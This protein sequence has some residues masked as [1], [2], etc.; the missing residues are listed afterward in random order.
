MTQSLFEK[1]VSSM[2]RQVGK[3]SGK[4]ISN[5]VYKDA[6]ATP[7]RHVSSKKEPASQSNK[8][9]PVPQK[10]NRNPTTQELTRQILGNLYKEK[11]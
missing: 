8:E 10:T 4:V 7:I 2:V 5:L 11:K 6:H 3:D 9:E 1:F